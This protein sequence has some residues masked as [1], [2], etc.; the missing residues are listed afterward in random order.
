MTT[1]KSLVD[2]TSNIKDELVEC[3]TNLKNNLIKKG[4]ECSDADKMPIL[5]DKVRSIKASNLVDN[6]PLILEY[7][8]PG[9]PPSGSSCTQWMIPLS[10]GRILALTKGSVSSSCSFHYLDLTAG[11]WTSSSS[12]FAFSSNLYCPLIGEQ[13]YPIIH[14]REW[15]NDT[16]S[17]LYSIDVTTNVTTLINT[18]PDVATGLKKAVKIKNKIYSFGYTST[19]T[20]ISA[21]SLDLDTNSI[22]ILNSMKTSTED[23]TF[24][25]ATITD[26]EDTI[27][28]LGRY[29]KS[30]TVNTPLTLWKYTISTNKI[31]KLKQWTVDESILFVEP[32]DG[33]NMGGYILN[34]KLYIIPQKANYDRY[35]FYIDLETYEL[36][37]TNTNVVQQG[38]PIL[39]MG[40]KDH[41]FLTFHSTSYPTIGGIYINKNKWR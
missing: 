33:G 20:E 26:F 3:H 35:V 31:E 21:T 5:V 37:K 2:E 18:I 25:G 14:Y 10:D 41:L 16:N 28:S 7:I 4:V 13:K 32:S 15:N 19:G 40:N 11:K 30:T 9:S 38:F 27:Y 22:T 17:K 29:S 6:S 8:Y 23:S 12:V 24:Y 39:L 36:V 34:N 1:L